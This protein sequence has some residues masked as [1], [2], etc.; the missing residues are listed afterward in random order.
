MQN[1]ITT[2][3]IAALRDEAYAANDFD[4]VLWCGIALASTPNCDDEGCYLRNPIT[5]KRTTR[6]V[7]RKVCADAIR[8]AAA[9]V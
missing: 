9:H 6:N 1:K 5:G 7:A 4:M 3:Q 8:A 2:A